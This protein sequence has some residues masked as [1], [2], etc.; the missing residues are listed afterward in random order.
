[1]NVRFLDWRP[2]VVRL[3]VGRPLECKSLV[4][5]TPERQTSILWPVVV[6]RLNG[7]RLDVRLLVLKSLVIKHLNVNYLNVKSLNV[8]CLVVGPLVLRTLDRRPLVFR[9]LNVRLSDLRPLVVT[10]LVVRLLNVRL[11]DVKLFC[12]TPTCTTLGHKQSPSLQSQEC[13]QKFLVFRNW[14]W[15]LWPLQILIDELYIVKLLIYIIYLHWFQHS[16]QR[17]LWPCYDSD[18]TVDHLWNYCTYITTLQY[19]C[20]TQT[21]NH[22]TM[23]VY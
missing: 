1:M 9:P 14:L 13:Y 22:F 8:R 7:R 23:S 20:C 5:Y 19:T 17:Q 18:Y 15:L 4:P 2:L 3:L 6:R 12:K 10:C 11:L 16:D 21:D